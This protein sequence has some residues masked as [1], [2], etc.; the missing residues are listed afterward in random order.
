MKP[1]D[2]VIVKE[3]ERARPVLVRVTAVKGDTVHGRLEK[4]PHIKP[5]PIEVGLDSVLVNLGPNPHPGKVYGHDLS[6]LFNSTKDMGPYGSMHFFT[7]VEPEVLDKFKE[8]AKEVFA[9]LKKSRLDFLLE[10]DLVWQVVSRQTAGKYGGWFQPAKVNDEGV[11]TSAPRI[12]IT[13]DEETLGSSSIGKYS[14]VI[15]HELG[16]YL[17]NNWLSASRKFDRAWISAFSETVRPKQVSTETMKTL[18]DNFIASQVSTSAFMSTLEEDDQE[19]FRHAL[20]EVKRTTH[21]SSKDLN[22]LAEEESTAEVVRK[23]W[24]RKGVLTNLAPVMTE[25]ALK[26]YYELFAETFAFWLLG[27]KIP[28]DLHNLMEQSVSFCRKSYKP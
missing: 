21:L 14:Y 19:A 1:K 28:K 7:K 26:N 24:P 8:G 12:S 16:H 11:N 17:H 13:L 20:K 23:S 18:L 10:Q 25:Y 6:F 5:I 3:G 9:L 22:A 27:R 4:D 2:Y 15:S